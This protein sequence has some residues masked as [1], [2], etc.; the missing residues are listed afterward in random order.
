MDGWIQVSDMRGPPG[1][2]MSYGHPYAEHAVWNPKFCVLTDYQ[3]FL[4][5][6]E[7]IH[8]LLLQGNRTDTCQTRLLRRTISVPV[9][10]QF[11]EFQCH[12][13]VDSICGERDRVDVSV[14][15]GERESKRECEEYGT[16]LIGRGGVLEEC[17]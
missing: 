12:L 14:C 7:E 4:L 2:W 1:N 13:S 3:M 10:T 6:R 11:P 15:G 8:P 17:G 5:D 16:G 9:E